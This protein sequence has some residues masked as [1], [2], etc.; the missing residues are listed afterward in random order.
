MEKRKKQKTIFGLLLNFNKRSFIF[1]KTMGYYMGYLFLGIIIGVLVGKYL[2]SLFD[3]A[4]EY[5]NVRVLE[6]ASIYQGKMQ[7]LQFKLEEQCTHKQP[8][9]GFSMGD[10]ESELFCDEDGDEPEDKLK[11]KKIG[12]KM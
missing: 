2:F 8:A 12:F 3:L 11:A 9:I 7:I 1:Y 4:Y 5:I 6:R 10:I